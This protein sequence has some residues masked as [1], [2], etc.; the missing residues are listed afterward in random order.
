M[1]SGMLI[2]WAHNLRVGGTSA[3]IQRV[4]PLI[5]IGTAFPDGGDWLND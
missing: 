2:G 4:S 3:V 5:L 1:K